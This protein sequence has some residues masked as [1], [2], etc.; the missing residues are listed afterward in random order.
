MRTVLIRTCECVALVTMLGLASGCGSDC[1]L[2]GTATGIYDLD[3]D[4]I[5]IQRKETNGTPEAMIVTYVRGGGAEFPLKV[6]APFPI[7]ENERKDLT[8]PGASL[9]HNTVASGTAI[10]FDLSTGYIQF[11]RLGGVG[12]TASGKF[13]A[14]A[15]DAE[16]GPGA[17]FNGCFEGTVQKLSFD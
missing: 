14:T 5:L 9:E 8:G 11:D 4:S 6:V 7:G 1:G 12:E 16:G 10:T 17:T 13:F 2:G 15:E 3:Y